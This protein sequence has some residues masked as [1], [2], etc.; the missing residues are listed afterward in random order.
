MLLIVNF[1]F[2]AITYTKASISLIVYYSL[3]IQ[4]LTVFSLLGSNVADTLLLKNI[5]PEYSRLQI[6][7]RH[8]KLNLI[9]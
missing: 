2:L 9:I 6:D 7:S 5:K 4:A 8:T 3:A 1:Q